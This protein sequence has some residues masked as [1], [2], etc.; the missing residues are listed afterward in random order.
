MWVQHFLVIL[1]AFLLVLGS[2]SAQDPCKFDQV[3]TNG[4]SA[5]SV[6]SAKACFNSIS[7]NADWRSSTIDSMLYLASLYSFTPLATDSKS[8]GSSYDLKVDLVGQ[9]NQMKTD[10]FSS[11]WDFH[12]KMAKLFR[13]LYD[14]HTFYRAPAPYSYFWLC[15]PFLLEAKKEQGVLKIQIADIYLTWYEAVIGVSVSQHVGKK[16]STI[17]GE[18]AL[19]WLQNFSD[20]FYISKDS[21]VR[22]NSGMQLAFMES[23]LGAIDLPSTDNLDFKFEGDSTTY[24]IPWVLFIQR[25]FTG[26]SQFVSVTPRASQTEKPVR[27]APNLPMDP[28]MAISETPKPVAKNARILPNFSRSAGSFQIPEM[29]VHDMPKPVARDAEIAFSPKRGFSESPKS[30]HKSFE[31]LMQTVESNLDAY[32]VDSNGVRMINETTLFG[33]TVVS[34]SST[35]ETVYMV[36][37][38]TAIISLSTFAPSGT[39]GLNI[40]PCKSTIQYAIQN[41]VSTRGIKKLLLDFRGNGG[42]LVCLSYGLQRVLVRDWV[43]NKLDT[44][45]VYDFRKNDLYDEIVGGSLASPSSFID[46]ETG[47]AFTNTQF[48]TNGKTYTRGGVSGDYTQKWYMNCDQQGIQQAG[49]MWIVNSGD[50]YFEKIAILTDGLCGSACSQAETN[51]HTRG[52]TNVITIGGILGQTP[53]TSSFAGG[54]VYDWPTF[55]QNVKTYSSPSNPPQQLPT[56]AFTRFNFYEC[57]MPPQTATLPREYVKQ[58]SDFHLEMWNFGDTEA[59]YAA[60]IALNW[61]DTNHSSNSNSIED[62]GFTLTVPKVFVALMSLAITLLFL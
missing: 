43:Q 10:S 39:S 47:R 41:A 13:S 25:T 61:H 6:S 3:F 53:E 31:S 38:D 20:Q 9:L 8:S 40:G 18:D 59:I 30:A 5:T 48:Y 29:A 26:T 1:A 60:A 4:A 62:G 28:V 46:P 14:A 49:D 36:S 23:N 21:S 58:K 45:G 33:L 11:E 15:Q 37:D 19:Q 55:V 34:K 51:L 27:I 22:F 7:S 24:S 56:T 2:V 42:G 17:N 32:P 54:A 16:I 52:G 35:G 50:N 44:Y 12:N 57:Y